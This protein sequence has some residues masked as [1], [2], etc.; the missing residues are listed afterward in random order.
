M[1]TVVIYIHDFILLSY[2]A[3]EIYSVRLGGSHG[4]R[5]CKV[6][7]DGQGYSLGSHKEC[8]RRGISTWQRPGNVPE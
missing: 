5:A 1:I 8:Y 6:Y 4:E 2:S 7:C 3:V